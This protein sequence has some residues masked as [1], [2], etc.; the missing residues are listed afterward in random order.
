MGASEKINCPTP[1]PEGTADALLTEMLTP[2]PYKVPEKTKKKAKGTRKSSRR[3]VV[4][5]S[6]SD[7]SETHSSREDE[8]KEDEDS[9]PPAGGD[10]KRKAAPTGG[11]KGPRREGLSFRTAPPPSPKTKTSGFSGPSPWRSRKYSDTRV[12]HSIPLS[13]CF[14]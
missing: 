8:E 1:L 13:H 3:Q 12:T 10:K 4:S 6:S 2:A 5:D 11:P 9:P 7:N 14:S